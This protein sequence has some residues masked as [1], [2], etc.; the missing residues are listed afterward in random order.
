LAARPPG[1]EEGPDMN[2]DEAAA[3]VRNAAREM[4]IHAG[5]RPEVVTAA[6]AAEDGGP[7]P[8]PGEHLR[9][10][11]H[12]QGRS[13][14]LRTFLNLSYR[15]TPFA[16]HWSKSSSAHGGTPTVVH[17]G[18]VVRVVAD[19][20]THYGFVT[21]DLGSEDGAEY[22]RR[23]AAGFDRWVSIGLDE[24]RA[25]TT[26][27]WPEA[28]EGGE[29][30]EVEPDPNA[31]E[32]MLEPEQVIIDGGQ[33]GELTGVSVPAQA[34]AVLEP[35]P[36]L[37]TILGVAPAE[38][39][40]VEPDEGPVDPEDED[41]D[42]GNPVDDED[43]EAT[44]RASAAG[45]CGCGGTCSDPTP[46]DVVEA[47]TA[48]AWSI[49]LPD[50]PPAEWFEE[51]TDV[52]VTSA[53]TITSAGRVYGLVAP[54]G[55]GH[56]AYARAGR[57][58]EVPYRTVDYSRFMGA[59]TPTAGGLRPAGALTMDCGHAPRQRANHDVAMEHYDNAC[60]IIGAIA[61]GE[62][63]R[64][65]GVWMAGALLPGVRPD[66]IA[67]ALAC[68]ASGDWQP[69]PDRAG[70]QEFTGCLLVPV[71]GFG[72]SHA[73]APTT[74]YDGEALVASAVPVRYVPEISREADPEALRRASAVRHLVRLAGRPS[75]A[76]RVLAA[77]EGR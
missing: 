6:A 39:E 47:V 64:L 51:P 21:L 77:L 75:P 34:E 29:G 68:R 61:V 41:P 52:E 9:T 42:E 57:R 60:S 50:L 22:A 48:A 10:V 38:G 5:R 72:T 63:D 59:Q 1:P 49:T 58:L 32:V 35:T 4:A 14:G 67:R 8:Q 71:P 3:I 30:E 11:M 17:V 44:V 53:L 2:R 18:N 12:V 55:T 56:R 62:S 69:H 37:L 26:I 46:A 16:F 25:T 7:P 31:P 73:S 74:T 36:E 66:Q 40:E 28:E 27:V 13:T 43:D 65:G 76:Q 20:D 33:V 45:D 23:V 19:G 70:W 54:L 24:T 15:A